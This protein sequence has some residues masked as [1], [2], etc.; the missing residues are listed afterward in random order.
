MK[1][2]YKCTHNLAK[3]I[4][5]HNSK[6]L[7]PKNIQAEK[8]CN[9][10]VEN[11]YPVDGACQKEIVIHQ[12]EVST[13]QDCNC[14]KYVGLTCNTFKKRWTAHKSNFLNRNP[15]NSTT[16]SHHMWDLE[17]S[18]T[19]PQITWKIIDRAHPFSPVSGICQLCT[20]EKYYIIYKP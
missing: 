3:V 5:S 10:S 13:P 6:I 11:E 19:E 4:S 2:S 16:L 14:E 18:Q 1:I 15:K 20:K 12:S 17:D 9:C 7:N 8:P